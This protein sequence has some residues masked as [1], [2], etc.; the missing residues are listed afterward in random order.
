MPVITGT[1]Y[2]DQNNPVGGRIVRAYRRSDGAFIG[3]VVSTAG[4]GAF[5]IPCPDTEVQR[6]ALDDAGG[7]L[8]ND[9][10]DRVLPGP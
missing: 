8:Y 6:I 5:S 1:V 2:D 3:E 10:I 4:T 9:L 7:T